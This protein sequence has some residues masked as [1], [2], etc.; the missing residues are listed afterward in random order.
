MTCYYSGRIDVAP[1]PS[2][3]RGIDR[4]KYR[5]RDDGSVDA[6]FVYCGA[7]YHWHVFNYVGPYI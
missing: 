5:F 6:A 3:Y 1:A 7:V 2:F 4:L